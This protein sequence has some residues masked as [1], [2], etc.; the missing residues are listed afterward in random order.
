ME[1]FKAHPFALERY[2]ALYE[3]SAPNL[4]CCSD[5][6]ALSMSELLA[7]ADAPTRYA[8]PPPRSRFLA[9]FLF[10]RSLSQLLPT[11]QFSH[12]LPPNHLI[13]AKWDNLSLGY[14]ESAGLPEL[15]DAV[16]GLY[17]GVSAEGVLIGALSLFVGSHF[18][19]RFDGGARVQR[20]AA[21]CAPPS[22]S[23]WW[24]PLSTR[25]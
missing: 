24:P 3:F 13:R 11:T 17:D 25:C 20:Y 7:M 4:L 23:L 5:C 18:R 22:R 21:C 9:T 16:A 19:S 14:T 10:S 2:F 1:H 6:E 12:S 15:R 8:A